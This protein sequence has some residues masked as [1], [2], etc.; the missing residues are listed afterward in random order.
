MRYVR[1]PPSMRCKESVSQAP[2]RLILLMDGIDHRQQKAI[3]LAC[4]KMGNPEYSR[5]KDRSNK[6][7][8]GEWLERI[9][10]GNDDGGMG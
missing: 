3:H 4:Y 10:V 1:L 6:Q 5:E 7:S 2:A 9:R 8:R